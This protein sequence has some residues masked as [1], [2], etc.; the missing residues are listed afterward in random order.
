MSDVESSYDDDKL[1][2]DAE[3]LMQCPKALI[4]RLG[5][6][7]KTP[8]H[9]WK[10]VHV[11]KSARITQLNLNKCYIEPQGAKKL[12]FPTG[13]KTLHLGCNNIGTEK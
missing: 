11:G 7:W 12:Q 6:S 8:I 4:K 2:S 13:L 5:W 1:R 10:G 9:E 3:C